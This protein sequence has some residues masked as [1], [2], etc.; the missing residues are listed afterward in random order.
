[1]STS[2]IEMWREAFAEWVTNEG[3]SVL[4]ALEEL[5]YTK[6]DMILM[7]IDAEVVDEWASARTEGGTDAAT[8]SG[9]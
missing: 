2:P 5:N 1:M 4:S 7:G 6:E 3:F 8:S 9:K